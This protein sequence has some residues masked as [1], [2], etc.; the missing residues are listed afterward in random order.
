MR[1]DVQHIPSYL[2]NTK[3]TVL[4]LLWNF[5]RN[6]YVRVYLQRNFFIEKRSLRNILQASL[7]TFVPARAMFTTS[8]VPCSCGN[9]YAESEFY[10]VARYFHTDF[11]VHVTRCNIGFD[12]KWS[13]LYHVCSHHNQENIMNI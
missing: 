7:A 11:L 3:Y 2:L 12:Q 8:Q 6:I 5:V 10:S 13:T 4:F 1:F 9:Y